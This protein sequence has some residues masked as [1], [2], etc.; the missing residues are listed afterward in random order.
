MVPLLAEVSRMEDTGPSGPPGAHS[1]RRSHLLSRDL[2]HPKLVLPQNHTL[3]SICTSD[4]AGKHGVGL[5]DSAGKLNGA[6]SSLNL[7]IRNLR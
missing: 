2:T 5:G 3:F 1:A 6:G 7:D 4:F